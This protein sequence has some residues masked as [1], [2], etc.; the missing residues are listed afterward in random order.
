MPLSHFLLLYI[1][2][3]AKSEDV[4]LPGRQAVESWLQRLLNSAQ[5]PLSCTLQYSDACC[6]TMLKDPVDEYLHN[7][8][9]LAKTEYQFWTASEVLQHT[10]VSK[11][12]STQRPRIHDFAPG[13]REYFQYAEPASR[14][15]VAEVSFICHL[16]L[17][18]FEETQETFKDRLLRL[19]SASRV[20]RD[21]QALVPLTYKE[22]VLRLEAAPTRQFRCVPPYNYILFQ[23]RNRPW[24]G[25]WV[26][27][28]P[29]VEP[30][31]VHAVCRAIES[32]ERLNSRDRV[33]FGANERLSFV[34]MDPNAI[35]MLQLSLDSP[36]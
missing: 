8:L 27:E 12:A 9:G 18:K 7:E 26:G 15:S 13:E 21:S 25:P 28:G 33:A 32:R 30:P 10:V 22:F 19:K 16:V 2:V 24:P 4:T 34:G 1:F 29:Q 6:E 35:G 36:N 3:V 17:F 5:V 31:F 23:D 20:S 14:N 11:P